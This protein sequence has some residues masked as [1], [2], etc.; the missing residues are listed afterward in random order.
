LSAHLDPE[1]DIGASPRILPGLELTKKP[2]A[3]PYVDTMWG[4]GVTPLGTYFFFAGFFA[5]TFFAGAAFLTAAFFAGA[6]FFAAAGFFA[7]I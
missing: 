7:A 6:A 4:V 5:A 2:W 3:G 1:K